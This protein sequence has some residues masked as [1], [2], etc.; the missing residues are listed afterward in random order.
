MKTYLKFDKQ[1]PY[2]K[3]TYVVHIT[4]KYDE[5][6]GLGKISWYA[7]WRQYCFMPEPGTV[8]SKGCLEEIQNYIKNLMSERNGNINN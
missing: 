4:N 3:L 8:F 5:Y 7:P 2:N 1:K 6:T